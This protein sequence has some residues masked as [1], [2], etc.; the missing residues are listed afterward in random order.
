MSTLSKKLNLELDQ[1]YLSSWYVKFQQGQKQ[2]I[3]RAK[4]IYECIENRKFV[5]GLNENEK[6]I[7]IGYEAVAQKEESPCFYNNIYEQ[8]SK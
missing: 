2:V 5:S 7:I 4:K 6:G 1:E 3:E 8:Y